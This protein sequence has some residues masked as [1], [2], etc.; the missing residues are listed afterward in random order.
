[1][2][3][4]AEA[5]NITVRHVV[6][7]G[8]EVVHHVSVTESVRALIVTTQYSSKQVQKTNLVWLSTSWRLPFACYLLIASKNVLYTT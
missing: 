3:D 6:T 2:L 1:M 5:G 7:L 8:H 4:V